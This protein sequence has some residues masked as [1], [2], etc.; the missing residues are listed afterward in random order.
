MSTSSTEA[1][2]NEG[3]LYVTAGAPAPTA[4]RRSPRGPPFPPPPRAT[5]KQA[6]RAD[7]TSP[8]PSLLGV[9]AER[10]PGMRPPDAEWAAFP[11]GVA[12]KSSCRLHAARGEDTRQGP[13]EGPDS[14]LFTLTT[15]RFSC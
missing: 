9:G 13:Q 15:T 4:G 10:G 3:P 11:R 5:W 2:N 14:Q 8:G 12:G 1:K 6:Q 7:T